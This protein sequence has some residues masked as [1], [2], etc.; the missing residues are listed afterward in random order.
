MIRTLCSHC[1]RLGFNPWL[2]ELL[3]AWP[4]QKGK[5]KNFFFGYLSCFCYASTMRPFDTQLMAMNVHLR[6]VREHSAP[7]NQSWLLFNSV[8]S[9]SRV[10]LTQPHWLQHAR[11]PCPSPTPRVDSNSCPLS[12]W[13]HSTISS[14]VVPFSSCLQSFPGLG[15]FQMSQFFTDYKEDNTKSERYIPNQNFLWTKPVV[16]K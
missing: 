13:C 12:Q 11:S 8:Q 6:P 3:A 4:G 2:G 1:Q 16:I 5:K 10:F 15:S 14:F 9:L 7:R